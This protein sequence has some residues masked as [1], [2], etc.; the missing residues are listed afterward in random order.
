[1]HLVY[2]PAETRERHLERKGPIYKTP[3]VIQTIHNLPFPKT[4][5]YQNH[6]GEENLSTHLKLFFL[7]VQL[8]FSVC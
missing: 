7:L 4:C 6:R 5:P 8:R 2:R 3:S 1:M